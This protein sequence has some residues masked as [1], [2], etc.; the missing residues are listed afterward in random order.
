VHVHPAA[1]LAGTVSL[2]PAAGT[3]ARAILAATLAPGPSRIE[4]TAAGSHVQAMADCC[5]LLGAEIVERRTGL[6]VIGPARLNPGTVLCPGNSGTVLRLLLGATAGLTETTFVTPFV[7]SLGRRSNT[8]MAEALRSLGTEV[9][10]RGPEHRMPI[11]LG[12]GGLSGGEVRISG[13]RTPDFLSGLLYLGGLLPDGL[14]ITVED[15]L[16][17]WP[18]VAST[19]A[20]LWTAGISVET[21]SSLGRFSV[22]GGQSFHPA[23]YRVP[24][25]PAGAAAVLAIA[26]SVSSTVDL[27]GCAP[28]ELGG[29]LDYLFNIGADIEIRGR[30]L[31]VRGGAELRPLDFDG[32]TAPDAV[33]PLAALAAH[34]EGTSRFSNLEPLRHQE[35]DRISD[36]RRELLRVGIEAD[37]TQDE[38]IIHGSPEGVAG[39]VA[40]DSH[41]D[42]AIV[43]AMT[44]VGLRSRNGL[45]IRDAQYAAQ[46]YPR[47]FT[48]LR[49]LGGQVT[50]R[51]TR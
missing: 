12:G 10:A 48:D 43:F 33:L 19:M 9:C 30:T 40:V 28:D 44:V 32:S 4:T 1:Q 36:F 37:E 39:G 38:L 34:A 25:D 17:A 23:V 3:A 15:E 22:P 41:Y 5:R 31:R 16:S 26:A 50:Q 20:V 8:E 46:T 47:F 51:S 13:R 49:R 2:P 24:N 6:D 27:E 14:S 11:T 45:T 35:C 18:V 42:H 21:G 7:D 29:I